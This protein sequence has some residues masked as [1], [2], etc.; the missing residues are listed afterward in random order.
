MA[1]DPTTQTH[2]RLIKKALDQNQM[3]LGRLAALE[4]ALRSALA[5]PRSPTEALDAIPGRRIESMLVGTVD[6][7]VNARGTRGNPVTITISQDGPFVATHYPDRK[8]VV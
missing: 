2:S 4:D 3:L 5:R 7:D 6:F 1:T 8:S